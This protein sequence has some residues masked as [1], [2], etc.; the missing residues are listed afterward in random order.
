MKA[1]KLVWVPRVLTIFY[2]L[3]LSIFALDVFDMEASVIEKIGGFF[4]HLIPSFLIIVILLISWKK[5]L[6]GGVLFTFV[7]LISVIYFNTYKFLSNF[8]LISLPP[9]VV[10]LLFIAFYLF[11]IRKSD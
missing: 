2:V 5:P 7:G 6:I 8:L 1:F 3:F 4:I 11:Y 9:I 10:G